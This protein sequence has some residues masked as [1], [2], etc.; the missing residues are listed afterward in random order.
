MNREAPS[1]ELG[2]D[3]DA[4]WRRIVPV[5][6]RERE[7]F[8]HDDPETLLH[9]QLIEIKDVLLTKDTHAALTPDEQTTVETAQSRMAALAELE[10]GR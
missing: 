8:D 3:V 2:R 5:E 9:R 4:I 7:A 6:T 10:D 1:G